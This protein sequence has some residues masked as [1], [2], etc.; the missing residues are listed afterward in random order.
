LYCDDDPVPL[1]PMIANF[2][3]SGWFGSDTSCAAGAP[4]AATNS[5]NAITIECVDANAYCESS[6]L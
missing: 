3:E 1:S 5:A 2:S 4:I 6:V